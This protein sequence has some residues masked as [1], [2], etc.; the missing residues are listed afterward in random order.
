MLSVGTTCVSPV[1]AVT[2]VRT[3]PPVHYHAP[4]VTTAQHVPRHVIPVLLDT[5]VLTQGMCQSSVSRVTIVMQKPQAVCHVNQVSSVC[6][7]LFN[8]LCIN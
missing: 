4:R 8:E 1:Q 7:L 6:I 5:V 3:R 2:T